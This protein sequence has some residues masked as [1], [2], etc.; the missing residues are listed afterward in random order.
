MGP[1]IL[2]DHSLNHLLAVTDVL[3]SF[4]PSTLTDLILHSPHN[5]SLNQKT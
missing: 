5:E 1:L 2:T 4:V 3:D